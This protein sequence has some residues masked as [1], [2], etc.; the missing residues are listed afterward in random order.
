LDYLRYR[1]VIQA[2]SAEYRG[3]RATLRS[4][5]GIRN[6]SFR[7]LDGT[8]TPYA[9]QHQTDLRVSKTV[10]PNMVL[11]VDALN[12]WNTALQDRGGIALSGRWLRAS[13]QLNW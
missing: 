13:F 8:L 10:G 12:I 3:F 11:S 5:H 9:W 1:A 4:Q 7:N 6:G 2:Q